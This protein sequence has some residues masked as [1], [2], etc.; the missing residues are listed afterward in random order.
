MKWSIESRP[1]YSV[2]KIWLDPGEEITSEP[3]A[4]M[5]VKGEVR[6]K[7]SSQ[8]ILRGFL[9]MLAGESF[10]LNTY[11]AIT[12]SEIWFVPPLPGDISAIRINGD[13]V[14]QDYSY[15]AHYGDVGVSVAW[16][17]ARGLL[18]E[19]EL[20][21]LKASGQG[22]VWVNAYG[23]IEKVYVP[24]GERIVVD[25][26]HFVAMPA[27]VDYRIRMLGGVKTTL[28]GGE[29]LVVEV[30]GPATI[31]LQTRTLPSLIQ[32]MRRFLKIRD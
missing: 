19:G 17:G 28:F 5:L 18:A 15:L 32:V 7:T 9:R 6:V 10:F 23:A 13:W 14:I 22:I 4:M 3:G 20:V 26:F 27:S 24:E 1:S 12:P 2:L 11:Q 29:G 21:W 8:G 25:N 16:R 30:K 31:Y